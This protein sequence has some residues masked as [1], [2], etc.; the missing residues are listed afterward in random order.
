MSQFVKIGKHRINLDLVTDV[1]ELSSTTISVKLAA[2]YM[3]SLELVDQA[4]MLLSDDDAKRLLLILDILDQTPISDDSSYAAA[5]QRQQALAALEALDNPQA[6]EPVLHCHTCGNPVDGGQA[7]EV[8]GTYM[9]LEK[10][11]QLNR[12]L[13]QEPFDIPF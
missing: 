2:P 1:K 4:Q 3:T 13:S 7:C 12:A 11:D 5:M 10:A 9:S 8:C 6:E